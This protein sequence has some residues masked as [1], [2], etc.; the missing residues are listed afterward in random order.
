M[1]HNYQGFIFHLLSKMRTFLGV[2]FFC[3]DVIVI[4]EYESI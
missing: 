4:G 1:D 2:E 3:W